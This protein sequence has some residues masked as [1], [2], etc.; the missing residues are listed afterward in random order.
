MHSIIHKLLRLYKLYDLLT[1]MLILYNACTDYTVYTEISA[2]MY[3]NEYYTKYIICSSMH[4]LQKHAGTIPTI[5]FIYKAVY[6]SNSQI[7]VIYA[8]YPDY[9]MCAECSVVQ[10]FLDSVLPY[11]GNTLG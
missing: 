1:Q 2:Y 9:T 11:V 7:L 10:L 5:Q 6:N 3:K 4:S 8:A